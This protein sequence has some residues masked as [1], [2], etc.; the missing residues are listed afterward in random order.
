M[1]VAA[2]LFDVDGTLADTE[3]SHRQA[4]NAAFEAHG[5]PYTWEPD[6]Y[7][8]LLRVPGGKERL[9][10]FFE[11]KALGSAETARL[12]AVIPELHLTKTRRY[13]AA[14]AAGGV[15]LLPGIARLLREAWDAKIPVGIATTTTEANVRA[16]VTAALGAGAVDRFAVIAAGDM[17]QAKKPAPDVYVL[18]LSK[19]GLGPE[20]V[21]AFE[22][23]LPGL[24]AAQAAGLFTV[25]TPTVWA[26]GDDLGA[27]DL[28]LPHLGDPERPLRDEDARRAGGAFVSLAGLATLLTP[29][30]R[31]RTA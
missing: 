5:L 1:T 9:A 7:H 13:E 27:A 23:S 22:D 10:H 25:V 20:R 11:Q 14:V 2:L 6:E 24:T 29:L 3:G 31:P 12:L 17:V 16:L 26:R 4:F 19:L 30:Q 8:A 28:L 15:P 18:A 21:V